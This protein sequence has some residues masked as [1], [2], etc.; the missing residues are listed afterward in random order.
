M[1]QINPMDLINLHDAQQLD[2]GQNVRSLQ[3][4]AK[5]GK[6]KTIKPGRDWLTTEKWLKESKKTD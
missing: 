4:Q 1:E 2:Y 5:A 3:R 6:F